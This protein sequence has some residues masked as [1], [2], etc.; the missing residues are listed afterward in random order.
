MER[1][2]ELKKIFDGFNPF[3]QE[4]QHGIKGIIRSTGIDS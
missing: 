1:N 3:T 4:N 2:D